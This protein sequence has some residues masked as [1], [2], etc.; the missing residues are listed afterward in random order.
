MYCVTVF[1]I[2]AIYAF[3]SY[4]PDY[5]ITLPPIGVLPD[6]I[7]LYPRLINLHTVVHTVAEIPKHPANTRDYHTRLQDKGE[8]CLDDHLKEIQQ[9]P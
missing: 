4:N 2:Q 3:T 1:C 6:P 7:R 5:L 8:D 9:H